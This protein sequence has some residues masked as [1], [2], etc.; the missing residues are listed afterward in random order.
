MEHTTELKVLIID[1][2]RDFC[3]LL[4]EAL[5]KSGNRVKCL[6]ET[7]NVAKNIG[8]FNPDV[9]LLDVIIPGR[10]GM[11]VLKEIKSSHPNIPIIMIS[12]REDPK[13]IVAAINAGATDYVPKTV[14][15]KELI[16][17]VQKLH[18]MTLVI[19]TETKMRACSEMI[20]ESPCASTLINMVSLVAQS[21]IPVFLRGDSGTGKSFI[22]E[23]IHKYS[24]R[25][26]RPFVTINCPAI[27]STLLESEL[28]GHEKG[29]FTG[30]IKAKEGKFELA[31][32]G[33][34]FLED[35]GCLTMDL[36]A[37]LLRVIQNKEFERVGGLRTI[38]VDVRIIAATNQNIEQDLK[39]GRFREDLYY[40]LNVLPIYVPSLRERKQDIPSLADYFLKL[41]SKKENKKFKGLSSEVI[42]FLQSYDWPGNIR[43]LDNAIERA[44]LLGKEP[45]LK[46]SNFSMSEDSKKGAQYSKKATIRAKGT[47]PLTSLKDMERSDLEV[48]LRESSGNI[49]HAAKILGISRVALYRRMKK[50]RIGLKS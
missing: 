39:E 20:G 41:S 26:G 50:H 25:K 47:Q 10:P 44:V 42:K 43:E 1:D 34:V 7:K 36:Q 27:A 6:Y 9:I 5:E 29:S 19:R 37:K 12:V 4:T 40:R 13:L 35:V 18:E 11:D 48:A 3:L 49:S 46:V 45:E 38:K 16:E 30:A 17:K 8:D 23:R 33:T 14:D 24:K 28:F 15:N 32:G 22:A 31:N 21:D 2:D